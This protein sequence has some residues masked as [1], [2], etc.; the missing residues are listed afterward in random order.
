[1][2]EV[3]VSS[4]TSWMQWIRPVAAIGAGF[5]ADRVRC[6]RVVMLLF[7]SL[8]AAHL[9]FALSAPGPVWILFANVIVTCIA[10][11]GLRG[12]YF[13]LFGQAGLPRVVTG[14]AVGLVSVIGYTPDIFVTWVAGVLT[15]RTPGLAG[16]Q[17]FFWFLTAFS[18]VGLIAAVAFERTAAKREP[19]PEPEPQ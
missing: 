12:V 13:A 6:S 4:F 19:E 3:E 16:H 11:F 7:A 8:V 9:Y 18:A 14:S 2:S 17:H 5:V 10:M 15:V 1:M